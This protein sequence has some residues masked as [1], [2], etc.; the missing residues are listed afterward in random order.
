MLVEDVLLLTEDRARVKK[1][2]A[3][4]K[5]RPKKTL[6]YAH[7]G[8]WKHDLDMTR[9]DHGY[10]K[11]ENEE[12]IYALDKDGGNCYGAWYPNR[13]MG[14]TFHH[15]RPRHSIISQRSKIRPM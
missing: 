12:T 11:E 8:L 4:P 14:V 13:Q 10:H 2:P 15:P 5:K 9:M 6:W 1:A 7:Q 3:K